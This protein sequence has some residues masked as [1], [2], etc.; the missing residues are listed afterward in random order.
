MQKAEPARLDDGIKLIFAGGTC[1][2]KAH[3]VVN[4]MSEDIDVKV[5][6]EPAEL[7]KNLSD[8]VRLV[9]Q[10]GQILADLSALGYVLQP[11]HIRDKHRYCVIRAEHK[12]AYPQLTTLRPKLQ[13]ELIERHPKLAFESKTFGCL[14][15]ELSGIAAADP[16]TFN[17]ISVAE[18]CSEKVLSFLRRSAQ[19]WDGHSPKGVLDPALVRHIFDVSHIAKL[20]P[21]EIVKATPIFAELVQSDQRISR[22]KS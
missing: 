5:V 7:S 22:A 6:L 10:H 11:P 20:T 15:E 18:T 13:L 12:S 9:A 16:V 1:L 17:Y 14:F 21:G 2:A 4:R 19:H 3:A 8:R